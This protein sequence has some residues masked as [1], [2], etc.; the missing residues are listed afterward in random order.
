MVSVRGSLLDVVGSL[1]TRGPFLGATLGSKDHALD[2]KDP[3]MG[4]TVPRTL[5]FLRLSCR[6]IRPFLI[7]QIF[8]KY[9]IH[10]RSH[11]WS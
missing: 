3:R 4:K 1:S 8:N 6:F 10:A 5:S 2:S 9:Q 7:P 11:A